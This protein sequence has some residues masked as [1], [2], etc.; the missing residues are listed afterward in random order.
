MPAKS[1]VKSPSPASLSKRAALRNAIFAAACLP[2]FAATAETRVKPEDYLSHV[3]FLASDELKGR[4]T[5]TAEG[6]KAAKYIAGK[7]KAWGL[8]PIGGSY[9]QTFEVTIQSK[10]G[11]ATA[12]S[13]TNG[14]GG[15]KALVLKETF[16]VVGPSGSGSFEGPLVFAGYGITA[17]E[18]SYDDYAGID[19]K[20]KVVVIWR[21]E[22]QKDDDKSRFLGRNDTSHSQLVNKAINAK[23]HGAKAVI[24]VN[25]SFARN[26]DPLDTASQSAGQAGIPYVQ[27]KA[28]VLVDWFK[29]AGKSVREVG[30]GIDKD[31]QP[32]S[33]ALPASLTV[34][35][36]VEIQREQHKT[37]N[38][39][40]YLPGKTA[41]YI[42]IGAHYD[43]LGLG[44]NHSLGKIGEIHHGADD[45]AS[46]S[47]GMLELAHWFSKQP[48]QRRG[49]LFLSFTGEELGL[50]GSAYYVGHPELPLEKCAAMINMD[51]IGRI[52]DGKVFLAGSGTGANFKELIDGVKGKY[53]F[54]LDLSETAGYGS[55]D[56]TSFTTKQVPV[57]FFFS[58]LHGDYHK[59]SDTWDKIDAPD[60]A[61]LLDLVSDIAQRLRTD[62]ERP[63]YVR[64]EPPPMPKGASGG[65][66]GYGPYFGSIPDFAEPPK[67][68]RFADI[69]AGSPAEKAGL[70]PGDI[71]IEFD[72]KD[73]GNLYDYTYAL[74]SK[75]PGDEVLVKV[76]RS[77]QTI[78]AKVLL[79]PRQ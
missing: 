65:G 13:Y 71:M 67:G 41:E 9:F 16:Q 22:P 30:E 45:N 35:G 43:H 19:V 57:L 25:P 42:V 32:R 58:G 24:L 59:P 44:D 20:D 3:K 21:H 38:V 29:A 18:Y 56:H 72:G 14:N 54:Q 78:E 61:K 27:V 6:D 47:A 66:S 31:L 50:L 53:G 79:T 5:G 51:M 26:D 8:K 48:K 1:A 62:E 33:F 40:G 36:S 4:A 34:A 68:V 17:P 52:R 39:A 64:V 73:I 49:I 11:P 60:A 15:K 12:F 28:D 75:K 37:S 10:V 7:F 23:L 2:L 76:I 70:K 46:G 77:G 63:K 69:R 55:S 74:R